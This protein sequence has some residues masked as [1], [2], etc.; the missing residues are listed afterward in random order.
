VYTL[1]D[2]EKSYTHPVF[3]IV[4]TY[5]PIVYTYEQTLL[6]AGDSA[7]TGYT[8]ATTTFTYH[9]D[10]DLEPLTQTQTITVTATSSSRHFA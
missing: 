2:T 3:T 8:Q 7:I 4:P 9:Y 10:K 6:L 5:C 1:T